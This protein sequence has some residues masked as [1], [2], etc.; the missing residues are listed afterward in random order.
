M[1]VV[2]QEQEKEEQEQGQGQDEQELQEERGGGGPLLYLG[3]DHILGL[4][5]SVA[6]VKTL[7]FCCWIPSL[8]QKELQFT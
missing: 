3:D 2:E 4:T 5:Q 8:Q 7:L 1:V 6:P